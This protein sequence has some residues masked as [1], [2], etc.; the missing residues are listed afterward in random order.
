MPATAC[1]AKVLAHSQVAP[2]IRLL[3]AAWPRADKAPHA[4]QFFMLR[5]WPDTAWPS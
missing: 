4:G 3:A 5:C 2:G 1:E